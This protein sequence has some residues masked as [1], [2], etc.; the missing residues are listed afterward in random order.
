MTHG[1]AYEPLYD[2]GILAAEGNCVIVSCNYR[3]GALGFLSLVGCSDRYTANN[4][5]RDIVAALEWT[6]DN[7]SAWGG[8]PDNVTV[9]GESAGAVIVFCL[10]AMPSAQ[11][12]FSKAICQSGGGNEK[13]PSAAAAAR[14]LSALVGDSGWETL[15]ECSIEKILIAQAECSGGFFGPSIDPDSLPKQPLVALAAGSCAGVPLL[16][17][18]NRDEP[19]L[20]VAALDREMD[21]SELISAVRAKVF[22]PRDKV[23][24]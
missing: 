5:L 8:D 22:G 24:I 1:A 18:T 6:Q 15:V 14:T 4:G 21:E 20:F 3:T 17:G 7:I 16:V 10:L 12:L 13:I 11:G 23:S 2:G 9:F 19:K